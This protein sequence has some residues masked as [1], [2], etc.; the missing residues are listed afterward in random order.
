MGRR[1]LDR[2]KRQT[3]YSK[4]NDYIKEFRFTHAV[5]HQKL[6]REL[7]KFQMLKDFLDNMSITSNVEKKKHN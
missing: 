6:E 3:Y 7:K 4:L 2:G 5:D 1:G